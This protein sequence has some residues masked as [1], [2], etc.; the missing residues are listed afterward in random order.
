[1]AATTPFDAYRSYQRDL[2]EAL[3]CVTAGRLTA[4]SGSSF[5][6]SFQ[7][8]AML[9]RGRPVADLR[10]THRLSLGVF[11]RFVIE[12][13]EEERS[14]QF[15]TRTI[16][17]A[18]QVLTRGGEELLA[19]HWTPQADVRYYRTHPHLHVGSVLISGDA[20][21]ANVPKLH[22]PTGVISLASVIRLLIEEL[23]V[24]SRRDNWREILTTGEEAFN[25]YRT[26]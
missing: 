2:N 18:Y 22:I 1:M 20:P 4:P 7:Y 6:T 17:Y 14:S 11:Q 23:G 24:R 9:N 19:F 16:E 8:A 25:R 26:R 10:G 3:G 13:Y 15:Y 21:I 5:S 12:S